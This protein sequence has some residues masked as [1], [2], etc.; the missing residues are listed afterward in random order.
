MG[1]GGKAELFF[2]PFSPSHQPSLALRTRAQL[3]RVALQE[4][5]KKRLWRR[6]L[7]SPHCGVNKPPVSMATFC[8]SSLLSQGGECKGKGKG[9]LLKECLITLQ[10]IAYFVAEPGCLELFLSI[11][12]SGDLRI[13]W[14]GCSRYARPD[15]FRLKIVSQ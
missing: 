10:T 6:Q 1:R 5:G 15:N 8:H 2:S 3:P 14:G 13:F 11:I 4:P 9:V 12:F 7:S